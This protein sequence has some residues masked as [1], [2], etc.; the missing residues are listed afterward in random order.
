MTEK[1]KA[2]PFCGG[3]AVLESDPSWGKATYYIYCSECGV[4]TLQFKTKKEV[5]TVWNRRAN[6]AEMSNY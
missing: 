3:K 2:C 4:E 5:R 1:L 6:N